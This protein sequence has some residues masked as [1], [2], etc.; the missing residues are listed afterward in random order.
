MGVWARV[1]AA[2]AKSARAIIQVNVVFLKASMSKSLVSNS[3]QD[4]KSP[5][6]F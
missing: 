4:M 6:A 2:I 1:G 5:V 3:Q